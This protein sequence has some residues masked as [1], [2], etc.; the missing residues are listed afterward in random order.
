MTEEKTVETEATP[1]LDTN[2]AAVNPLERATAITVSK[3]EIDKLYNKKLKEFAKKAQ[4]A[5][6][7]RGH[8]PMNLVRDQYGSRC[9]FDALNA[10]FE[11]AWTEFAKNSEE[12]IY[13]IIEAN[14]QQE[15]E[16]DEKS[17]DMLLNVRYEVFPVVEPVDFSKLSLKRYKCDVDAAAVDQT[18]EVMRKQRITYEEKADGAAENGDRV[19]LDFKGTL[20]GEEFLGGTAQDFMFVLG[21]GQ[22]LEDFEKAVTG[23]KT[24]ESKTFPLTFPEDYGPKDL[25][26]KTVQFEITVKKL[27]KGTLPVIDDEFA[28]S[29]GIEGGVEQMRSEIKTNLEREVSAR[30]QNRMKSNVFQAVLEKLTFAIPQRMVEAEAEASRK[31]YIDNMK[32]RNP[33]LTKVPEIPTDIFKKDASD[34]L[35]LGLFI[36]DLIQKEK[37]TPTDEQIARMA[38]EISSAYEDAPEVKDYLIATQ[39]KQ[40]SNQAA[41]ENAVDFIL[42]QANTEEV[43]VAFADVMAGKF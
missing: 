18:L 12:K 27:E 17:D 42:K 23:M 39:G 2:D 28:S 4:M 36:G 32:A 15:S 40:L 13:G 25:N 3:A 9:Y 34:R 14:P 16:G 8:V 6:F 37:L 26:G 41:E 20:D 30:L 29:L 38:A 19:T 11:I 35:R 22:M 24:G 31:N 1:V 21:E 7:R 10:V 5:G 33:S 43:T